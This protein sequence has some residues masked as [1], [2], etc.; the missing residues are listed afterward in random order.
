[1]SNQKSSEQEKS[2]NLSSNSERLRE[3]L[4][5]L[6]SGNKEEALKDIKK[7][8]GV[9][10]LIKGERSQIIEALTELSKDSPDLLLI[11]KNATLEASLKS[12]LF[13]VIE[14]HKK[15]MTP[16]QVLGVLSLISTT[17]TDQVRA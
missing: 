4:K 5:N 10:N 9:E 6:K 1:M 7:A 3:F 17:I 14:E 15:K 16:L 12:D 13:D 11:L 2:E 8:G